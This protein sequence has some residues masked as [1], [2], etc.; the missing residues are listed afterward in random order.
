VKDPAADGSIA[1]RR[2][3]LYKRGCFVL[4][5]KQS[6]QQGAGPKEVLAGCGKT[7]ERLLF[8][9]FWAAVAG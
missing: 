6:R 7:L 2:I 8:P 5:A 3:D 4:E 1:S 9:E